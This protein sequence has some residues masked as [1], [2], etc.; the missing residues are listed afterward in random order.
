MRT[1]S[2]T[3]GIFI[4]TLT[5]GARKNVIQENVNKENVIQLWAL[6]T[7]LV[8]CFATHTLAESFDTIHGCLLQNSPIISITY[9]TH[10]LLEKVK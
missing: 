5:H 3:R 10:P 9:S 6:H 8:A 1:P 2:W 4:N 7:S